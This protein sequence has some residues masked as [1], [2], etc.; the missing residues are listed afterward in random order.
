MSSRGTFIL[1]LAILI[2]ACGSGINYT[3]GLQPTPPSPLQQ[4]AIA[5]Y[6]SQKTFANLGAPEG[7]AK[8]GCAVSPMATK[9]TTSKG[10][11]VYVQMLC[12]TCA[13][14]HT[15]AI[16]PVVARLDGTTV[17]SEQT[18]T[19]LGDPYFQQQIDRLFPKPLW[20]EAAAGQVPNANRLMAAA[21]REGDCS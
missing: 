12:E 16:L 13:R 1:V 2:S 11:V 17:L 7:D 3:G 18:T 20:A 4:A 6:A 14:P 9:R 21:H 5:E 10:M 8:V 19:A 15:T